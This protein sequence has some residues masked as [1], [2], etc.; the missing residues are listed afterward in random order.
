MPMILPKERDPRLIT[1]PR[2]GTLTDAHHL[3]AGRAWVRGEVRMSDARNAAF[4]AHDLG[5]AAYAIKAAM[6]AALPDDERQRDDICWNV[7][8]E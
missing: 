1:E 4:A 3:G 5:A 2:G 7:F 8:R 6:A